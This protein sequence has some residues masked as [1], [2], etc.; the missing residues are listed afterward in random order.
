MTVLRYEH[1]V[2]GTVFHRRN[3]E[4]FNGTD[5]SEAL[6][7]QHDHIDVLTELERWY[8]LESGQY[9]M[10]AIRDAVQD[11]IDTA[12]GYHIL[13][14]GVSGARPLCQD[15][16][17]NHRLYCAQRAGAGVG[18]VA[19]PEELP[20]E[21]DSVDAIIA[22]H[23]LEFAANPHQ[24]LR[25][26]QRVLTPQGQL[27]V[28]GFNP[29]SLLG[30]NTRMRGVM[31]DPLWARHRPLREHRLADWLRLLNCEVLDTRWLFALPPVGSGRLRRAIAQFD[32]WTAQ[33]NLPFGGVY[34]LHATK[35]VAGLN[36]PRKPLLARSKRL[37]GLVPKPAPVPTPAP[38][39]GVITQTL[40]SDEGNQAA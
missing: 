1:P 10:Q 20:L 22:H 24:V 13:Q 16:P 40:L 35:K 37:I 31:R 12:F 25:E 7:M 21:S 6:E 26:I 28:V 3:S 29:F 5:R 39:S 9:L 34:I 23:C 19:D 27:L 36:R 33:H 15:S 18:M 32:H 30:C 4:T 38:R 14:L 11:L 8:A 17:I 2:I